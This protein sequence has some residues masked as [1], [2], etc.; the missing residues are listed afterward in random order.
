MPSFYSQLPCNNPCRLYAL[1][2]RFWVSERMQPERR[3]LV[4]DRFGLAFLAINTLAICLALKRAYGW[5]HYGYAAFSCVSMAVTVWALRSDPATHHTRRGRVVVT[6]R[7]A[8]VVAQYAYAVMMRGRREVPEGHIVTKLRES[9]PGWFAV[10][11][12]GK[13]L[14]IR[15]SAVFYY[16]HVFAF[17]LRFP[18][19]LLFQVRECTIPWCLLQTTWSGMLH[20]LPCHP[21][22]VDL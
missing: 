16:L 5:G 9:A 13:T 22:F 8:R 18:L 7:I 4:A 17:P 11:F 15:N 14:L 2:C 12:L 1:G 20:Q 6:Q 21:Q 10:G 19:Q 3:L